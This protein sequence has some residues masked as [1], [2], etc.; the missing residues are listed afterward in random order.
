MTGLTVRNIYKKYENKPLLTGLDLDVGIGET[1]CLLGASGSGKST[2]LRIIA[3]LE[4]PDSGAILWDD[5]DLVDTP[6]HERKFGF[7]F[8]DY[9]LFPHMTVAENIAFGLRLQETGKEKIRSMVTDTLERFDLVGYEI[10]PGERPLGRGTAKDRSCPNPC[11][12]TASFI[13]G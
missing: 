2:L 6:T 9:A 11:T 10:P 1:V 5:V 8:Q 7:M 3:G 12:R 4:Q 13:T